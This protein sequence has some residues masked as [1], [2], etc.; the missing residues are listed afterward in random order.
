MLLLSG[1]PRQRPLAG[2][3][4][5]DLL[6][7]TLV[8]TATGVELAVTEEGSVDLRCVLTESEL[9]SVEQAS[10]PFLH[11]GAVVQVPNVARTTARSSVRVAVGESATFAVLP[12]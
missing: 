7:Q 9:T 11:K 6:M 4:S 1:Q 10:L 8:Q 12:R 3:Y 2:R 5:Y